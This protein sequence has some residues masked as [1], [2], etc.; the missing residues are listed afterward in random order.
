M[1]FPPTSCSESGFPDSSSLYEGPETS[2][3]DLY[4]WPPANPLTSPFL[5]SNNAII[6]AC[7]VNPHTLPYLHVPL[8]KVSALPWSHD[9]LVCGGSFLMRRCCLT[10]RLYS[11]CSSFP[12]FTVI[13]CVFLS[14]DTV[15]CHS[16]PL[17]FTKSHVESAVSDGSV[18]ICFPTPILCR[19]T[20]IVRSSLILPSFL[21]SLPLEANKLE[22]RKIWWTLVWS[23]Q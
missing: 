22:V 23:C 4:S 12:P 2:S 20:R 8:N 5:G 18:P 13:L 11:D 21:A 17:T 14:Y 9:V 19:N 10:H 16:F 15:V 6:S 1:S 7:T 3:C